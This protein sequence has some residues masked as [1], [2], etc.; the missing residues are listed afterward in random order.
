MLSSMLKTSEPALKTQIL[1]RSDLPLEESRLLVEPLPD[2]TQHS[3]PHPKDLSKVF[4]Q[5]GRANLN[6]VLFLQALNYFWYEDRPL[7]LLDE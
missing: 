2:N 7:A 5:R 6:P 4:S 1:E 3:E